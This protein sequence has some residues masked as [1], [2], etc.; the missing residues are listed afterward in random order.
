MGAKK[1]RRWH[2][3]ESLGRAGGTRGI[4]IGMAINVLVVHGLKPNEPTRNA[5]DFATKIQRLIVN[6]I[7]FIAILANNDHISQL[8]GS[9]RQKKSKHCHI[10]K[11]S[12]WFLDSKE[13]PPS[14]K[15]EIER[16]SDDMGNER[17]QSQ[18]ESYGVA[19]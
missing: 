1:R 18:S 6:L 14:E 3:M 19:A 9:L 4:T 16:G 7:L 17:I 8:S 12:G 13:S 2:D 11:S 15:R 5:T 10:K